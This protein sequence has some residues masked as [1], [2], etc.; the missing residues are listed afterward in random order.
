MKW[1]LALFVLICFGLTG[2]DGHHSFITLPEPP[3][4]EC[5]PKCEKPHSDLRIQMPERTQGRSISH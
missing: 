2:C 4:C 3:K 5:K 1:I